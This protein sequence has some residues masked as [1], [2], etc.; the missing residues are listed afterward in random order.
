[1]NK[2]KYSCPLCG[3]KKE[4]N[5]KIQALKERVEKVKAKYDEKLKEYTD[6]Y[7]EV[8]TYFDFTTGHF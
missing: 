5:K 8:L 7:K 2:G 3:A 1:M 4:P 6:R